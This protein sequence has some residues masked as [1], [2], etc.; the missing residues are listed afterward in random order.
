MTDKEKNKMNATEI[1]LKEKFE[2]IEFHKQRISDIDKGL[3]N[4][5]GG[6]HFIGRL[7]RQSVEIVTG[8]NLNIKQ[9]TL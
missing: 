8:H 1:Y 5:I 9:E 6:R 3:L 7:R 4:H 2:E